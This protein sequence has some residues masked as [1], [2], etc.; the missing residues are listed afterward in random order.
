MIDEALKL[1]EEIKDY[2]LEDLL[3]NFLNEIE[4]KIG[5][6]DDDLKSATLEELLRKLY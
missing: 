6:A 1:A 4:Q 3:N 2:D 5:D